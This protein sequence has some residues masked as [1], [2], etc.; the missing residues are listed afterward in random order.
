MST[1][2]K[3]TKYKKLIF[4]FRNNHKS[5]SSKL[6]FKELENFQKRKNGESFFF[7]KAQKE[8]G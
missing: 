7:S 2:N 1:D 8:E 3:N 5:F 6:L 4:L